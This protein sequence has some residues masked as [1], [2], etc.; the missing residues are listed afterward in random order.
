[1][2]VGSYQFDPVSFTST[3]ASGL[4]LPVDYVTI[5]GV[6]SSSSALLVTFQVLSAASVAT[7]TASGIA[8]AVNTPTM[9]LLSIYLNYSPSVMSVALATVPTVVNSLA[10]NGTVYANPASADL[11]RQLALLYS[12]QDAISSLAYNTSTAGNLFTL[13][14]LAVE[15]RF[16]VGRTGAPGQAGT[17]GPA[18]GPTGLMGP[19]GLTLGNQGAPGAAGPD[20][21]VGLSGPTGNPGPQ[22]AQGF[23][24]YNGH[25]SSVYGPPGPRGPQGDPGAASSIAGPQGAVG[26]TGTTGNASQVS[27]PRGSNGYN[28]RNGY[29]STVAGPLGPTGPTG[30][31]GLPST[32]PGPPGAFGR[33]GLNGI[34]GLPGSKGIIGQDANV[35]ILK[36]SPGTASVAAGP[37]GPS[38]SAGAP[39]PAGLNLRS[40]AYITYVT[41]MESAN[42]QSVYAALSNGRVV[43]WGSNPYG[44]SGVGTTSMAM[45]A[46]AYVNLP[47]DSNFVSITA[48]NGLACFLTDSGNVWCGGS[49]NA[50]QLGRSAFNAPFTSSTYITVPQNVP[51]LSNA[52]KVIMSGDVGSETVLALRFDGTV[53]GWGLNNYGTIGDQTTTQ[54]IL[55]TQTLLTTGAPLTNVIDIFTNT[56]AYSWVVALV[57]PL[58]TYN[59]SGRCISNCDCQSIGCDV[60]T[61]GYNTAYVLG[62][63][64]SSAANQNSAGQIIGLKAKG[65]AING[66]YGNGGG[67]VCVIQGDNTVACW[68]LNN[69]GQCATGNF[70]TPI[71]GPLLVSSPDSNPFTV[72]KIVGSIA[73]ASSYFCAIRIQDVGVYCWGYGY[74]GNVGG[75][76]ISNSG[77][78]CPY[79]CPGM[80]YTYCNTGCPN[81]NRPTKVVGPNGVSAVIA[82]YSWNVNITDIVL[83]PG[84]TYFSSCCGCSVGNPSGFTYSTIYPC[85]TT[86]FFTSCALRGDGT[87][88]C[89]GYGDFGQ[90]GDAGAYFA[91]TSNGG[92]NFAGLVPYLSNIVAI[93]VKGY[94]FWESTFFALESD[95]LTLWAWGGNGDYTN[96]DL[97]TSQQYPHRYPRQVRNIL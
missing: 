93:Y 30:P 68:G 15:A 26:P 39:G 18:Q 38:G 82:D 57:N 52:K 9:L 73:D 86:N 7:A 8:A 66:G 88:W 60:Y 45:Q 71:A 31:S 48:S 62:R 75:G 77:T 51:T 65:V 32:V 85:G 80:F 79:S 83:R 94:Q 2:T 61:W 81:Y 78:Q 54:R 13:T 43:S 21:L 95:R 46:P 22:G 10:F 50:K 29:G 84:R 76:A 69:V 97:K 4:S 19:P 36:G 44:S 17:D 96:G 3:L 42:S 58:A 27:G 72:S 56:E 67:S 40:D 63:S 14:L 90:L 55:P 24:G 92:R 89:W 35:S 70:N 53:F 16:R 41:S 12:L 37:T 64:V 87:V 49:N 1:V 20:G 74:Y 25:S 5:T 23:P 11:Y 6:S 33:D 47:F 91:L 59:S 34:N 28:G